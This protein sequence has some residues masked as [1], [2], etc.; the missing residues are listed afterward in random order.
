MKKTCITA[1]LKEVHSAI[2]SN[3]NPSPDSWPFSEGERIFDHYPINYR[4]DPYASDGKGRAL[5]HYAAGHDAVGWLKIMPAGALYVADKSSRRFF[6]I[7]Y[8]AMYN[9]KE[10]IRF[11]IKQDPRIITLRDAMGH[12]PLMIG[13]MHGVFHEELATEETLH[14]LNSSGSSTL[15]LAKYGM[16]ITPLIS[17][18]ELHHAVGSAC[19]DDVSLILSHNPEWFDQDASQ[20]LYTA[21]ELKSGQNVVRSLIRHGA[22]IYMNCFPEHADPKNVQAMIGAICNRADL[23]WTKNATAAFKEFIKYLKYPGRPPLTDYHVFRVIHLLGMG[24]KPSNKALMQLITFANKGTCENFIYKIVH[25]ACRDQFVSH[26]RKQFS[27]IC[28]DSLL[29][30]ALSRLPHIVPILLSPPYNFTAKSRSTMSALTRTK[31]S[32]LLYVKTREDALNLLEVACYEQLRPEILQQDGYPKLQTINIEYS[33]FEYH[34]PGQTEQLVQLIRRL[35]ES[36]QIQLAR[37]I[38]ERM[39]Y[40]R[41]RDIFIESDT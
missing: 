40:F 37:Q 14:A 18:W 28:D 33:L 20:L 21:L 8:A 7:H 36:D 17:Q 4:L 6:P 13:V 12:T 19:E 29:D 5:P 30:A 24:A 35:F 9:C 34:I 39:H 15:H 11:L 1:S 2:K 31:L 25:T 26:L 3:R 38:A 23:M 27:V 16:N 10:T 22:P 41:W 32:P